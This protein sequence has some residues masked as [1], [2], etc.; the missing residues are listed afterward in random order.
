MKGKAQSAIEFII[1]VGGMLFLF[2]VFTFYLQQRINDDMKEQRSVLL[3]DVALTVQDEIAL[4][5]ESSEGYTRAFNLPNNI[6]QHDYTIILTDGYVYVY[7]NDGQ[8]ALSFPVQNV[9]GSIRTGFNVVRKNN[10]T[11]YL[12]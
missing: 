1:I 10:G 3:K 4:A 5:H 2:T 7:T 9:T 11:V 12:N 6:I 8:N